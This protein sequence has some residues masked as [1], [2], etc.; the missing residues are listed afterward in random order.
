[1][2]KKTKRKNKGPILR[3]TFGVESVDLLKEDSIAKII[4]RIIV[5][6][7]AIVIVIGIIQVPKG[8]YN[9]NR[10]KELREQG[11]KKLEANQWSSTRMWLHKVLERIKLERKL[12]VYPNDYETMKTLAAYHVKDKKRRVKLIKKALDF[13]GQNVDIIF[14]AL[15]IFIEVDKKKH[16][17]EAQWRLK[18]LFH[19]IETG[20]QK[21]KLEYYLQMAS[22]AALLGLYDVGFKALK[23]AENLKVEEKDKNKYMYWNKFDT[24]F[25]EALLY[26]AMEDDGKLIPLINEIEADIEKMDITNSEK[27]SLYWPIANIYRVRRHYKKALFIVDKAMELQPDN[28]ETSSAFGEKTYILVEDANKFNK[29]LRKRIVKEMRENK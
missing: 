23:R 26:A 3:T 2:R 28:F 13:A 14:E 4:N 7:I 18:M 5:A 20:E 29:S 15:S 21:R 11:F 24:K 16:W 1:M 27:S 25:V 8:I 9:K 10:E 6:I 19:I 22:F 12:S 17:Y